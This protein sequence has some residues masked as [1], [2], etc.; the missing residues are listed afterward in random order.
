M[1]SFMREEREY[2]KT[3]TEAQLKEVEKLRAEAVEAKMSALKAENEVKLQAAEAMTQ[4]AKAE[5]ERSDLRLRDQELV[6]L[7]A[8]LDALHEAKLLGDEEVYAVEDIIADCDAQD[9]RLSALL[10]LSAK[11][12]ADKAFARQLRRKYSA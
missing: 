12:A 11:M 1:V 7:Q 4:A 9:D 10:G 6:A 3:E 8:R 2:M 5:T